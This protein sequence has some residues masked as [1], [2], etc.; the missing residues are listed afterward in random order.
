MCLE[1][2]PRI[3]PMLSPILPIL[4]N[5]VMGR[6]ATPIILTGSKKR[7]WHRLAWTT[8]LTEKKR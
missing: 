6:G 8:T 2:A 5:K 7:I 3:A 4:Y 1:G